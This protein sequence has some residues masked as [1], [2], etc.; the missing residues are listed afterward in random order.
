MH[1][2][3]HGKPLPSE[4]EFTEDRVLRNLKKKT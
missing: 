1:L 4:D 3:L 2:L